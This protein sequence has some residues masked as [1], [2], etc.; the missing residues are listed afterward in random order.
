MARVTVEDCLDH[1][2]N[3][4]ELVLLATKRSRQLVYGKEAMLPWENDKPTVLALREIAEGLVDRKILDE[5]ETQAQAAGVEITA[6]DMEVVPGVDIAEA[7][8]EIP[9][10]TQADNGEE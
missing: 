1:V 5:E 7:P 4:F 2:A 8:A 6:E 9:G 10:P 3:R